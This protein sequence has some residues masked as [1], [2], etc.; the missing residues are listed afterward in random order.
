MS[1]V[2]ENGIPYWNM[3]LP[4]SMHTKEC[5]SYLQYAMSNDKDRTILSTPDSEYQRQS[6]QDVQ[7]I[8][9]DNRLDLFLRVPSDL[10]RYRQYCEQ[11]TKDYG[12]VMA[13]VMQERL[14]WEDLEPK[15][16]PFEYPGTLSLQTS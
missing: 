11:L 13:F 16:E 8:I 9:L 2:I 14:K 3:N 4:P 1:E 6:W 10:R 5:P 7:Q 15:G 12:S